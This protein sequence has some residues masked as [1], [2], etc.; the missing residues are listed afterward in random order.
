MNSSFR[1]GDPHP[2]DEWLMAFNRTYF[3]FYAAQETTSPA[4]TMKPKTNSHKSH[5]KQSNNS[6]SSSS[7]NSNK[8]A[9]VERKASSSAAKEN[10]EIPENP[11]SGFSEYCKSGTGTYR[12]NLFNATIGAI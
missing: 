7:A 4:L 11:N 12:T 8:G 2:S 6:S 3:H 10:E 9:L 5:K 1:I